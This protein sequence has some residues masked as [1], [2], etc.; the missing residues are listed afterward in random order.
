MQIWQAIV[1]GTAQGLTEFLPVS[2]SGHL[3]LLQEIMGIDFGGN[4][5]FFDVMLHFGTLIAVFFA[6]REQI[7]SLFRKPFKKLFL[8]CAAS[9]P[10][11]IVGL[12]FGDAIG[13]IFFGGAYLALGFAF[14]ALLLLISEAIAKGRRSEGRPLGVKTGV[15]MGL[16]Q[17]VAVI[18]G[19][20]RSGSTVAAGVCAGA[21]TEEVA[22]FSFLMSIPVILGSAAVSA[23][24][25]FFGAET[26]ALG[27]ADILC[28]SVGMAFAALSGF[29]AIRLMLKVISKGNY[30]WFAA[31]LLL[32][33]VACVFLGA[34]GIL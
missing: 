24:D 25:L 4:A 12:F 8:L 33:S 28:V 17:A 27:A 15:C 21:K 5:L 34:Y 9:V 16:M 20:S 22:S 11:G 14:T 6:F 13:E 3:V 19:I 7:F 23:K 10:A 18:P 30:K 26:A 2:S 1:L 32:L 29:F 31:Y